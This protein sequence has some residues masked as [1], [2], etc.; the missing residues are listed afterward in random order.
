MKT[1]SRAELQ[2]LNGGSVN[3]YVRK[4][5]P[6]DLFENIPTFFLWLQ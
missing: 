3:P 5:I 4:P 2:E 1:L 6:Q